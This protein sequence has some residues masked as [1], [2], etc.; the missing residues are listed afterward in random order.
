MSKV[1]KYVSGNIFMEV[2]VTEEEIKR[3]HKYYEMSIYRARKR[4]NEFWKKYRNGR[5]Q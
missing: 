1:I 3:M 4:A 5:L 2:D